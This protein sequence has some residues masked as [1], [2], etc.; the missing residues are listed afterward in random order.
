MLS[1]NR[2]ELQIDINHKNPISVFTVTSLSQSLSQTNS[3]QSEFS[4][5]VLHPGD[6]QFNVNDLLF[7]LS[8][9]S[10]QPKS[11][12]NISRV[13]SSP[14]TSLVSSSAP[15]N[16]TFEAF[17]FPTTDQSSNFNGFVSFDSN[18]TQ[19]PTQPAVKIP[20]SL[21]FPP[22]SSNKSLTNSDPFAGFF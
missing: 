2:E 4:P 21:T 22:P 14:E 18:L 3:V 7:G 5:N 9:T 15:P 16:D 1:T 19:N 8:I 17:N 6:S 13:P 20:S 10:I 12:F 11:T